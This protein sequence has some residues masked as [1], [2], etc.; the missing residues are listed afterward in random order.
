MEISKIFG[1]NELLWLIYI[2]INY[3]FVLFAYRKWGKIGVMIFVPISI[4]LANIQVLKEVMLFGT[5]TTLGNIA[6]GSIFL[7]SDILSENYGKET[8]KKIVGIGFLTMI[9]TTIVMNIALRINVA[10]NDFAQEHLQVI[11]GYFGRLTIASLLAY[12]FS[13]SFDIWS[14]QI[15]RKFRPS[16]NDIWIRNNFSTLFSQILDNLIFTLVAFIGIHSWNDIISIM[17]STYFLKVII[18]IADTPFVYIAAKW[19]AQ[20]KIEEV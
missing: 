6:Y 19:K 1:Y 16:Y 3:L 5:V 4:I 15:I 18:S 12:I 14:Y 10:P 9:F 17:F 2:L 7:V 20:G 13:S 11:F 8:A